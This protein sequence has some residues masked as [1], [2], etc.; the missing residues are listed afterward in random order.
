M[1]FAVGLVDRAL[2]C[3]RCHWGVGHTDSSPCTRIGKLGLSREKVLP[4]FVDDRAIVLVAQHDDG[5]QR[6]LA[7]EVL[8]F[9]EH[10]GIGAELDPKLARVVRR[11]VLVA[12]AHVVVGIGVDQE[13][14]PSFVLGFESAA[15]LPGAG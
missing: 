13:P 6:I 12:S 10:S 15:V 2:M 3:T 11:A 7:K 9:R 8:T 14:V 1:Q 4:E 5:Q